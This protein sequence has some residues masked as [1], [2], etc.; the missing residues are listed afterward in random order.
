MADMHRMNRR[1]D[2]VGQMCTSLP[3]WGTEDI[4][5]WIMPSRGGGRVSRRD[6]WASR[7][8]FGFGRPGG[9]LVHGVYLSVLSASR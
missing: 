6:G 1:R 2:H 7:W 8:S 9:K 5:T 3:V 4:S